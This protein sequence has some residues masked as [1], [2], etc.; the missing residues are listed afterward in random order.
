MYCYQILVYLCWPLSSGTMLPSGRRNVTPTTSPKKTEVSSGFTLITLS[1]QVFVVSVCICVC[2]CVREKGGERKRREWKR[3]KKKDRQTDKVCMC[4]CVLLWS[5]KAIIKDQI[6]SHCRRVSWLRCL[7][8]TVKTFHI[9]YTEVHSHT[10][11]RFWSEF[12][13]YI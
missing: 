4:A 12:L 13:S 6:L 3:M 9:T 11:S 2:V 1:V 10:R 7:T 5:I 8:L